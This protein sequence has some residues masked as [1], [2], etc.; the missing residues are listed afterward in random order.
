MRF[1]QSLFE[2]NYEMGERVK[3]C[4]MFKPSEI[5][6]PV[7]KINS[8]GNGSK[9]TI[10]QSYRK[11]MVHSIKRNNGFGEDNGDYSIH[12]KPVQIIWDDDLFDSNRFK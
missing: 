12:L 4:R 1:N 9:W 3:P 2:E 7:C 10:G 6:I 11:N 8:I 5:N